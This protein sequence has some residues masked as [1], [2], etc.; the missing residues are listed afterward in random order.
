MSFFDELALPALMKLYKEINKEANQAFSTL[1]FNNQKTKEL[2]IQLKLFDIYAKNEKLIKYILEFNEITSFFLVTLN[3]SKYKHDDKYKEEKNNE[4]INKINEDEFSEFKN[5]YLKFID[6][7]SN[8]VI[9]S[10]PEFCI[11]NIVNGCIFFRQVLPDFYRDF[12]LIKNLTNFAVIY[13]CR[14]D[15][16]HNQH[17]LSQIFDIISYSFYMKDKKKLIILHHFLIKNY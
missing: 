9:S 8:K 13:C 5:D 7:T 15:I 6:G 4:N 2:I 17:L 10:L 16:I 1:G 3:N 11:L 14:T 12:D